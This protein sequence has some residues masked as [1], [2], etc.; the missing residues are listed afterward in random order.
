MDYIDL[1][2]HTTFS[3]GSFT[4]EELLDLAEHQN[5]KAV[6]ITDHDDISACVPAR[7]YSAAKNIEYIPGLELSIE[8]DLP[9]RGHLHILA[10]Y[11]DN[12]NEELIEKLDWL[13]ASR[14]T[15]AMT[16]I[17]KLQDLGIAVSQ[18]D[19]EKYVGQGSAGRPHI[20][21]LLLDKNVVKDLWEAFSRYLSKGNPAYV[22]KQKLDLKSALDLIHSANGVAVLAHPI[23]LFYTTY[24]QYEN[25]LDEMIN[26]GL[27]GLEVYYYSHDWH[28]KNFLLQYSEDRNLIITGGSDFHGDKKPNIELGRGSGKLEVPYDLVSK[29]QTYRDNKYS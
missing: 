3:D 2:T 11:I 26:M 4:P 8:A 13:K 16:I 20:A 5:L 22:P 29:L 21:Q 1:H 24:Q 9:G 6:A 27:D 14:M 7:T 10:Y 12:E 17:N 18:N 15:R 28:F 19:L 25:V 23:S